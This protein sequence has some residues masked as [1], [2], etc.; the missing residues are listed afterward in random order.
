MNLNPTLFGENLPNGNETAEV[1]RLIEKYP[2]LIENRGHLYFYFLKER[3]PWVM[4]LPEER[5]NELKAFCMSIE[6]VRRRSQDYR[7]AIPQ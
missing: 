7:A 6:N 3:C 1:K 4:Q 5:R 2:A